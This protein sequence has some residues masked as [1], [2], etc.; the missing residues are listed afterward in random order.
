MTATPE[1]QNP[2]SS[3]IC[4]AMSVP[5]AARA[6]GRSRSR[7]FELIRTGVIRA[8]KDGGSTIITTD[9]LARWLLSLP[10]RQTVTRSAA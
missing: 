10:E 2:V 1:T 6:T 9:E 3:P 8:R 5:D 7:M 4:L